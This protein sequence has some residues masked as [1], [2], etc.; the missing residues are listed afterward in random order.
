M[1]YDPRLNRLTGSPYL[2][3]DLKVLELLQVLDTKKKFCK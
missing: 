3:K 1:N 2:M